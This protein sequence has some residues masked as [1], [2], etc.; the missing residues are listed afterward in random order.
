MSTKFGSLFAGNV[1]LHQIGLEGT[2]A[3]DRWERNKKVAGH[4]RPEYLAVQDTKRREGALSAK[5]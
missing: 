4:P 1:D 5:R 3:N 2:P